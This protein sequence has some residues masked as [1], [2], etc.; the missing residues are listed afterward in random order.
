MEECITGRQICCASISCCS[1]S[2][3]SV[4]TIL[5][6]S[7]GSRV[8]QHVSSQVGLP[9]IFMGK[10]LFFDDY[11]PRGKRITCRC[12]KFTICTRNSYSGPTDFICVICSSLNLSKLWVFSS[13]SCWSSRV[14]RC[15]WTLASVSS[16]I[17]FSSGCVFC[18]MRLS[19]SILSNRFVRWS[20]TFCSVSDSICASNCRVRVLESPR[21]ISRLGSINGAC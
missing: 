2:G 17:V 15:N 6:W 13:S 8:K 3:G 21:W 19:V 1:C 7:I 5:D 10:W 16:R 11:F 9:L 14:A 18:L 12:S 4:M 20:F